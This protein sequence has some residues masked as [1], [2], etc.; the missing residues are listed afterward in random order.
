M[1]DLLLE[2]MKLE[3]PSQLK[4]CAFKMAVDSVGYRG[5][6]ITI[7]VSTGL[8]VEAEA[9]LLG[10]LFFE[11]AENFLHDFESF[12]Q[13]LYKVGLRL[14]VNGSSMTDLYGA[15][16]GIKN[17]SSCLK[18]IKLESLGDIG[19]KALR[20]LS[21]EIGE[22]VARSNGDFFDAL[23]LPLATSDEQAMRSLHQTAEN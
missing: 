23:A 21:Q 15:I 8:G 4:H 1:Y 13:G 11:V 9:K 5:G 12:V 6:T 3:A 7:D 18:G 20:A 16:S 10:V 14:R 17:C 19:M 2:E 22:G